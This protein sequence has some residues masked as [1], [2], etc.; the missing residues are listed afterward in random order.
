MI[1]IFQKLNALYKFNKIKQQNQEKLI[2][3]T[4]LM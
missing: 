2:K 4:S 3:I 1:V